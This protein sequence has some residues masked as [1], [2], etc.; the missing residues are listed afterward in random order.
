MHF[1]DFI[2]EMTE[3]QYDA[4][5]EIEAT[6]KQKEVASKIREQVSEEE[7]LNNPSAREQNRIMEFFRRIFKR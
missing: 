1:A 7:A 4:W 6:R 3:E 2:D 5:F